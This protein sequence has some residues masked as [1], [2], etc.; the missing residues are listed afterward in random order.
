MNHTLLGQERVKDKHLYLSQQIWEAAKN[1]VMHVDITIP[2]DVE[3]HKMLLVLVT[4]VDLAVK[5]IN[6][7]IN[8]QVVNQEV[9]EVIVM[10]V[11]QE[12]IPLD[13]LSLSLAPVG[14]LVGRE[15]MEI[16]NV[17]SHRTVEDNRK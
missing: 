13:V 5:K 15:D 11:S 16:D 12:V 14:I 4:Q 7:A 9:V 2:V 10:D 1:K 3:D 17:V 8:C 6:L